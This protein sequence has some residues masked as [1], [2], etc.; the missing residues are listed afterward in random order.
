ML[1]TGKADITSGVACFLG[2]D[3]E[4]L[5]QWKDQERS[6]KADKTSALCLVN[7]YVLLYLWTCG[8]EGLL[9]RARTGRERG[10]AEPRRWPEQ[11]TCFTSVLFLMPNDVPEK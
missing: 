10:N 5:E 1:H 9:L 3:Q 7:L 6:G 8:K 2:S 11:V 4:Q